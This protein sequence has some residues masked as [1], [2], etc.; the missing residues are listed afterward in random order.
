MLFP[1]RA[2]LGQRREISEH[3][4]RRF[5]SVDGALRPDADAL[6]GRERCGHEVGSIV[7]VIAG[8]GGLCC[9]SASVKAQRPHRCAQSGAL[10]PRP[11]DTCDRRAT[12]P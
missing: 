5:P 12:G 6:F 9:H 4:G 10:G 2:A 1:E 8:M 3:I 11:S 7:L